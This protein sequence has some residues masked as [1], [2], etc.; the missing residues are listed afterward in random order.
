MMLY[1]IILIIALVILLY[2]S[3]FLFLLSDAKGFQ[4]PRLKNMDRKYLIK[5]KN[6]FRLDVD[7][8][9]KDNPIKKK[10]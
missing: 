4:A 1:K 8:Y 2:A 7:A 9:L 6:G 10:K 5:T 3:S